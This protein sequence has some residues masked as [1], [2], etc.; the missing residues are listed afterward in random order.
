MTVYVET[1]FL[2]ALAK[3]DDWLQGAARIALEE[4]RVQTSPYAYLELLF[5]AEAYEFEYTR[6][7][8]NL[9][10]LVPV[11]DETDQQIV[12]KAMRYFD[13]GMT[14]FDAFHAATA[15]T[16]ALSILSSEQD[17]DDIE[18]DRLPLEAHENEE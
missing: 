7:I 17:Y 15:E 12:L 1:D 6:L 5:V 18:V 10:D 13:E 16:R 14:P 11:A 4:R 8:P 9:L 2:V 3:H